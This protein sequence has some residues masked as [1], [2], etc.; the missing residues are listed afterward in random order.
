MSFRWRPAA[1]CVLAAIVAALAAARPR[2]DSVWTWELPAGVT[3]PGVP[4]DNPMSVGKVQLGRHLFYDTRLSGNGVQSCATCHQ[5]ARAFADMHPRSIGSTG[6]SHPRGSMSLVNVAYARALTWANTRLTR[7]EDQALVPMFGEHPVELGLDRSDSWLERLRADSLYPSLFRAAF[8][9]DQSAVTR[10]NVVRALAAFQRSIVS[11]RSPYDRYRFDRDETAISTAARRG[12]VLF[13]SRPLSCFT[14]HGG[15]HFSGTMGSGRM[16]VGLELHNTG[17]YNLAGTV[18]YPADNPGLYEVTRSPGD[19]GKFKAPTLRNIAVTAPYMHDG[20]VFTL[21][22][23]IDHY[24]AGGRTI[25][26]GPYRGV[27]RDNP[28]KSASIR[29][30]SL[31][32]DQRA[33]L[34]A[35]LQSLTDEHVL[36]DPRFGNPWPTRGR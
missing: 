31:T 19:V 29:G 18:S 21:E 36:R 11:M 16:A 35:F 7:L 6:Q 3:P 15:V 5:Q 13:H 22:E 12:E 17:L 20:S 2:A 33:D 24:A 25:A 34:V 10:T 27:G 9:D 28:N 32:A 4:S 14:C 1:W 26:D 23:A 8:P 30:F